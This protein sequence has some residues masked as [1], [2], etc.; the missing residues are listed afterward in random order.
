[1]VKELW[2]EDEVLSIAFESNKFEWKSGAFLESDERDD[3]LSKQ[4]SAFAN[5]EGGHILIGIKNDSEADGVD[6]TVK[7]RKTSEWLGQKVA[8]LL[9]PPLKDFKVHEIHPSE[10]S[11]IP[12]GKILLVIDVGKSMLAPHQARDL[13]YY[14][15]VDKESRPAPHRYIELLFSREKFPGPK[16]AEAW[17]YTVVNPTLAR[18]SAEIDDIREERWLFE[19]DKKGFLGCVRTVGAFAAKGNLAQLLQHNS[20]LQDLAATHDIFCKTLVSVVCE[21]FERVCEKALDAGIYTK[22]TSIERLERL[23]DE[24]LSPDAFNFANFGTRSDFIGKLFSEDDPIRNT[25]LLT[26]SWL[27]RLPKISGRTYS[28]FWNMYREDVIDLFDSTF[29]DE[30]REV[31]NHAERLGKHAE[32]FRN[33]L[34]AERADLCQKYGL[35]FE[36]LWVNVNAYT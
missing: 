1:M 6:L 16:V 12:G 28:S 2:T 30:T 14:Y 20:L 33:C 31:R 27:N 19:S 5:S 25:R 9:S 22:L 24:K 7:G 26:E 11:G 23:R 29:A 17:L 35:P 10:K 13:K 15:R 36:Q 34:E 21:T 8:D 18:M 32:A 3:K 4:L